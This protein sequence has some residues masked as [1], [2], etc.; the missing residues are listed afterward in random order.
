[1]SDTTVLNKPQAA[2]AANIT[3]VPQPMR[4]IKQAI[5][6]IK[7]A[8]P[9]TALT[10]RGLRSLINSGAVPC[11]RV[12]RKV[13]VNMNILSAY[14]KSGTGAAEERTGAAKIRAVKE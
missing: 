13:L 14:M 11:V 4:G 3:Y 2:E 1:M 7:A 5:A 6:E 10:E 9:H 12:G 8:D